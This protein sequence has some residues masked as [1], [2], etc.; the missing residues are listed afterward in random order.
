MTN[1]PFV[2]DKDFNHGSSNCIVRMKVCAQCTKNDHC[3]KD[4]ICVQNSCR[5]DTSDTQNQKMH[6]I[7]RPQQCQFHNDCQCTFIKDHQC[8][9]TK[10]RYFQG[11]RR[12]DECNVDSNCQFGKCSE[13]GTCLLGASPSSQPP[14]LEKPKLEN[15][16]ILKEFMKKNMPK[17]DSPC[18]LVF[19]E[20][21][22]LFVPNGNC[23]LKHLVMVEGVIQKN[24]EFEVRQQQITTSTTTTTTT[25][26]TP[27]TTTSTPPPTTTAKTTR[28][29]STSSSGKYG[30]FDSLLDLL[31]NGSVKEVDSILRP[32]NSIRRGNGICSV[33][34]D[35]KSGEFM[36]S[37]CASHIG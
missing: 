7:K 14:K 3:G 34:F 23:N 20:D 32:T 11:R 37:N 12:C 30:G 1:I 28:P 6:Q 19:D 10:C 4:Q 8:V 21:S 17:E 29:T 31:I 15:D 24:P 5:F 33:R 13:N 22:Q 16:P 36:S 35:E 26:S 2:L 27:P 9:A 18:T 25:T